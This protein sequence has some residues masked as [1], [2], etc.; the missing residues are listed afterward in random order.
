VISVVGLQEDR[1]ARYAES[2]FL[3]SRRAF[4]LPPSQFSRVYV[5]CQL[6]RWNLE[7]LASTLLL[8]VRP[9]RPTTMSTNSSNSSSSSRTHSALQRAAIECRYSVRGRYFAF[10]ESTARRSSRI[11]A[12][13]TPASQVPPASSLFSLPAHYIPSTITVTAVLRAA[14]TQYLWTRWAW[15]P[16][17]KNFCT[18][19][20]ENVPLYFVP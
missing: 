7:Q 12:H 11:T 20:H 18:V 14:K 6:V 9:R 17:K 5:R 19:G 1:R 16:L 10:T 3:C 2:S 15:R 8:D 13:A 4:H